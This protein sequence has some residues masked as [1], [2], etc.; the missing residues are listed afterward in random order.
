M[1]KGMLEYFASVLGESAE[2]LTTYTIKLD[3]GAR[4]VNPDLIKEIENILEEC[5]V[6][7][8][9]QSQ[10]N[11]AADF[12]KFYNRAFDILKKLDI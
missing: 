9:S 7:L 11:D 1:Y 5:S 6:Y 2:G 8:Y 10:N 12:K 4:N 3:L